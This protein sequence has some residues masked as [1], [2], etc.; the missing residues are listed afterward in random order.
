MN[1]I[2]KNPLRGATDLLEIGFA[3]R[4]EPKVLVFDYQGS[5]P[6]KT[7]PDS[8]GV[9]ILVGTTKTGINALKIR[10]GRGGVI[11]AATLYDRL[12]IVCDKNR[13]QPTYKFNWQKAIL[14]YNW[15]VD[16]KKWLKNLGSFHQDD[17]DKLVDSI[18]DS[19]VFLFEKY[20]FH[21][22]HKTARNFNLNVKISPSKAKVSLNTPD[23]DRFDEYLKMVAKLL[24][25]INA[26]NL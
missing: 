6:S 23:K 5:Q 22:L 26:G 12:C 10:I 14:F 18:M 4:Y 11:G 17:K 20:L 1:I 25:E 24:Q 19:E 2:S 3:S 21:E 7:V 15:N 8:K 13:D 9:Y 16:I